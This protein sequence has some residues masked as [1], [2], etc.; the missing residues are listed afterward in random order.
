MTITPANAETYISVDIESAGPN[1]SQYSLLAI[2]ACCVFFPERNFYIELKPVNQLFRPE[3]LESCGFSLEKLA[4]EGVDPAEALQ[5]FETWLLEV[6]PAGQRP[7]FVGFN[8]P[9][10]WMFVNDYFHRFLGYNPFGHAAIDIKSYYM[11]LAKV[12]WAETTWRFL[13]PHYLNQPALI[14]HALRDALD[15][16]EI[17]RKLLLEAAGPRSG[18][19]L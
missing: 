3:A 1:P 4:V 13:G 14:H 18:S 17:F 2:G 5:H 10:D 6:L 8:A 15:Q 12:P 19:E 16:G 7:V 9:F 11:G